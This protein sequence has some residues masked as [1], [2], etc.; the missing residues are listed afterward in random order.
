MIDIKQILTKH[1]AWLR[2]EE[3]GERADLSEADLS[4]AD[5]SEANLSGA[6]LIGADLSGADLSGAY[7]SGADLRRADLSGAN[8]RRADLSGAN[9]SR[10]NLS[11]ANLSGANLSRANLSG[12][13]LSGANGLLKAVDFFQNFQK[14]GEG[15]LVFKRL[16]GAA[17]H[18]SPP[19]KWEIREGAVIEEVPNTDRCTECGCGVNFGTLDYCNEN[20]TSADLWECLLR[21][22]DLADT[23]VPYMTDGKA[24]CARLTLVK[25]IS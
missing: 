11:G 16:G 22:E 19:A 9:L 23:V 4:E 12:A 20:S 10:A 17:T 1:A 13:N 14:S 18:Y 15:F 2:G 6:N 8:L 25:R 24:R 7:L 5:L 21:F 3:G